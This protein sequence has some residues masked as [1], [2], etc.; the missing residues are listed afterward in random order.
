VSGDQ[1]EQIGQ[2][3]VYLVIGATGGVGTDLTARLLK[4]GARLV[5]AG[6]N[7]ETL[8]LAA[9]AAGA[10]YMLCDVTS[11][12]QIQQCVQDARKKF[13]RLDG[14]ANCAG[15]IL[16]K[17]AHL[18]SEDEWSSMLAVNLTAAFATVKF[19]SRAMMGQGGSIVLV[20]SCAARVGLPNHETIAACK[21]GVEGL[22]RSTAAT[23]ARHQ[24]RVNCVAP[25][26]LRTNMSRAITANEAQL[27]A[28]IDMHPLG[29]IGTASDV[30]VVMDW[31]IGEESSWVTGQSIAVDGG[32]S[33][34]RSMR[35][36]RQSVS[37]G[38]AAGTLQAGDRQ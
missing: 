33:S 6:R 14:V 23:Y 9:D 29:R 34:V 1:E 2:P 7:Q 20:S 5:L 30:A 3:P 8:S 26:L 15:S 32:L 11:L 18:T 28:S 10:S 16:L 38:T 17:P 24:I 36:Q 12:D 21:A 22:V 13:G 25:G 35:A 31:L 19:A 27:Q 4:R 37:A